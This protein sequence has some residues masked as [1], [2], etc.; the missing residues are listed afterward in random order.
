MKTKPIKSLI[1]VLLIAAVIYVIKASEGI[2]LISSFLP[3]KIATFKDVH[4]SGTY[5]SH[6]AWEIHA[7][8]AWTGR[9]KFTTNFERVS[10]AVLYKNGRPLVV[11]LQARRVRLSKNKQIE[12]IKS[13]DNMP[14]EA[15]M[16]LKI[17]FGAV[18]NKKEKKLAYLTADRISFNP[19]TKNAVIEGNVRIKRE[20][21]ITSTE[22]IKMD[23]NEDIATFE[24]RTTFKK[25]GSLLKAVSAEALLDDDIVFLYGSVEVTQKS[26]SVTSLS[27]KYDDNAATITL[28]GGVKAVIEKLKNIIKKKTADVYSSEE[29]KRSLSTK[30]VLTCDKLIIETENNDATAYG[31]VYLTQK[32]QEAKS[33]QAVYTESDGIIIMTGNVFMKKEKDWVKANK[34]IVSVDKE[35]F[36]AVGNAETTFMVKKKKK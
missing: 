17:D 13:V 7:D 23:L 11:D 34:V 30:T 18:S 19:D 20:G 16:A 14:S 3:E 31:N 5:G 36:E 32:D 28:T 26:K 21:M 24:S 15:Y 1:W 22:K 6:E 10:K 33:E 35:R 29:E 12:V 27:G 8:E 9:D 25:K 4:M 2:N